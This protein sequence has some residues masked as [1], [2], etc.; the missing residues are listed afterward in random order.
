[1]PTKI[2]SKPGLRKAFSASPKELQDYF[3][4]IPKLL[5]DFPMHVCLAYV[6]SRL[7]LGQNMA[8]YCGAVRIHKVNAEVASNAVGTQ[9]LT[10][11]NFVSLYKTVFDVDIPTAAHADLKSAETTRDMVMHGKKPTD[12]KIRNAI[13]RVLEYAEEINKQLNAQHGLKPFGDLRGFAGKSKKLDK[14]T[15]RFLLKGM[16]FEIS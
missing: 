16:G 2:K 5:D 15:S 14:R 8:L 6:F 11:K 12:G 10:R 7:E 13:A 4:H 3:E 1:M 9:H